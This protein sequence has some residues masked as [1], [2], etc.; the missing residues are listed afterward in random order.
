MKHKKTT[1]KP[2]SEE[3]VT[4]QFCEPN[5]PLHQNAEDRR[6]SPSSRPTSRPACE[7]LRTERVARGEDKMMVPQHGAFRG[8]QACDSDV[9]S[10]CQD[11]ID[12]VDMTDSEMTSDDEDEAGMTSASDDVP[13]N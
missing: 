3:D 4:S 10:A 13:G 1:K 11:D 12:V 5:S 8:A 7:D 6:T 2:T 9:A